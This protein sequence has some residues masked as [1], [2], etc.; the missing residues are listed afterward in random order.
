MQWRVVQCS[1][2]RK[3][4]RVLCSGEAAKGRDSKQQQ[5]C[6]G[7][8]PGICH[9][10]GRSFIGRPEATMERRTVIVLVCQGGFTKMGK[11][12]W[13]EALTHNTRSF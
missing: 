11:K 6:S 9:K 5:K 1:G 12:C 8:V 3:R 2:E 7:K 4:L 10:R 13:S